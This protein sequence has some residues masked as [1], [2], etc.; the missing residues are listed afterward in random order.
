METQKTD[1]KPEGI[2]TE[3]YLDAVRKLRNSNPLSYYQEIHE[4]PLGRQFYGG[5]INTFIA[6]AP[7]DETETSA[8]ILA[9]KVFEALGRYSTTGDDGK[10][11]GESQIDYCFR[12]FEVIGRKK[13]QTL[14][15]VLISC[16][17]EGM[18]Q[19]IAQGKM[20]SGLVEKLEDEEMQRLLV[21]SVLP[22]AKLAEEYLHKGP[23]QSQSG[24]DRIFTEHFHI[25]GKK[26]VAGGKK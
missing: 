7:L 17:D 14:R 19:L 16:D 15:E 1:K 2:Q 12:N 13:V 6:L 9:K 25:Y 20:E 23:T 10:I 11:Q 5:D 18:K 21:V 24:S 22:T 4:Y 8:A 3:S 26:L